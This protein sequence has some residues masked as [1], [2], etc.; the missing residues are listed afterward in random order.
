[1]ANRSKSF[2]HK[3]NVDLRAQINF[4]NVRESQ[5]DSSAM[6]NKSKDN[7]MGEEIGAA[8]FKRSSFEHT[9]SSKMSKDRK[10]NRSSIC[11]YVFNLPIE[12]KLLLLN[13]PASQKSNDDEEQLDVPE[14][15]SK[16][17]K[18]AKEWPHC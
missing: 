3:Y 15:R 18:T 5:G 11:G 9:Q 1:M 7:N 6:E 16:M 4:F 12:D 2:P 8:G 13:Q 14:Y 10:L 17:V